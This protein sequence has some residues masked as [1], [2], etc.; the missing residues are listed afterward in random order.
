MA[1]HSDFRGGRSKIISNTYYVKSTKV[2]LV[3]KGTSRAPTETGRREGGRKERREKRIEGGGRESGQYISHKRLVSHDLLLKSTSFLA[4]EGVY[5]T[6][7]DSNHTQV[8]FSR[9]I[10]KTR[11]RQT[12]LI[13]KK[14]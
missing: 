3:K 4:R 6:R 7:Y 5:K 1:F 13:M 9:G 2:L 11:R 8:M 10:Y 12:W 14:I